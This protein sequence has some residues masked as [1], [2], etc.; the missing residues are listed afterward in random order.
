[1][2]QDTSHAAAVANLI[3]P[4]EP[5]NHACFRPQREQISP[6]DI[7][8]TKKLSNLQNYLC[9]NHGRRRV[10]VIRVPDGSPASWRASAT[11]KLTSMRS[12]ERHGEG[13]APSTDLTPSGPPSPRRRRPSPPCQSRPGSPS[14]WK[15]N[16]GAKEIPSAAARPKNLS[17][18]PE[19]RRRSGATDALTFPSPAAFPSLSLSL[20][21]VQ[22]AFSRSL[23]YPRDLGGGRKRR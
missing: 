4:S 19:I 13:R 6:I 8:K 10:A 21:R 22:I 15:R 3:S 2:P 7:F 14:P 20:S 11:V 12:R 23:I 17:S 9:A 18:L 1:V 16:T 5:V